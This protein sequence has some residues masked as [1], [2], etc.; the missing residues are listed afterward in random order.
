MSFRFYFV[1]YTNVT[2]HTT[3]N[4]GVRVNAWRQNSEY[5][6]KRSPLRHEMNQ[7]HYKYEMAQFKFNNSTVVNL[8]L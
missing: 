6:V 7:K 5:G 1:G 8:L 2:V 4:F 3:Q